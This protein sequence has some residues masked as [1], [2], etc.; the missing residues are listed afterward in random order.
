[1]YTKTSYNSFSQMHQANVSM[2]ACL[3]L[4]DSLDRRALL[5]LLLTEGSKLGK[6]STAR[7]RTKLRK[8][9]ISGTAITEMA[10]MQAYRASRGAR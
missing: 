7:L 5:M 8:K 4:A 2:T 9:I 10:I 1:M 3:K 6:E